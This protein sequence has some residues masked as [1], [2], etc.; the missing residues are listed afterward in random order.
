MNT[1]KKM[2]K[3]AAPAAGRKT[4]KIGSFSV[5]VTA[6]VIAIAVLLNLFVNE[7]P[8]SITKLDTSALQLF[9]VGE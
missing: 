9:T 4:L 3:A 6:V 5:T 7:L 8:G 2:K 1:E